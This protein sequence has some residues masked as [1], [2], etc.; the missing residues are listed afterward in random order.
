MRGQRKLRNLLITPKFQLKL[1]AQFVASGLIFFGAI[2][3]YSYRR[4]TVVNELM[5]GHPIMSHEVQAQINQLMFEIIRFTLGG[6]VLY[7]L[8]SSLFALL[9]SHRIAGPVVAIK[10]FIEQ[11]KLGNY[12]FQR[13][14]RPNDE[15]TEVMDA[16]KELAPVL[17]ER[18]G[19]Q[20]VRNAE[21]VQ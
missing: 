8:F 18:E 21:N 3:G 16:L 10:A 5:A 7:I 1:C 6:F 17:K 20:N 14:L 12:D 11:L 19:T 4:L 2:I 15:L 9:I 13:S